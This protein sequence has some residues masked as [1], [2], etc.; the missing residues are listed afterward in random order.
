MSTCG[1]SE[2]S[3]FCLQTYTTVYHTF[4][5]FLTLLAQFLTPI[6]LNACA[7]NWH[8]KLSKCIPKLR[9][10]LAHYSYSEF[11]F[12]PRHRELFPG[13]SCYRWWGTDP[14]HLVNIVP[15]R[16]D[17][18]CLT[19][20]LYESVVNSLWAKLFFLYRCFL[21]KFDPYI[22]SNTHSGLARSTSTMLHPSRLSVAYTRHTYT[23]AVSPN[24]SFVPPTT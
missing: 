17:S 10:R 4:Q 14:Q 11:P 19:S 5:I 23:T 16:F 1:V 2:S 20:R 21:Q 3:Q 24:H 7:L 18:T 6:A 15:T 8:Y 9:D 12:K 13:R 22:I